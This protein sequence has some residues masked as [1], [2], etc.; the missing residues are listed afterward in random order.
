M[1]M[2]LCLQWLHYVTCRFYLY[3]SDKTGTTHKNT[4][5]LLAAQTTFCVVTQMLMA[6][7]ST[8]HIQIVSP[9]GRQWFGPLNDNEYVTYIET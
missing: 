2:V 9:R 7:S 8:A 6:Y 1:Y 4:M 5:R 3:D